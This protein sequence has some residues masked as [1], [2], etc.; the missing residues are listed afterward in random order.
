[1]TDL[2]LISIVTPSFNQG[3]FLRETLQSLVDQNY[4]RLEVIIQDGGSTDD[5][6]A[7][8]GDFVR[9]WPD[10]F[11]LTVETD[12]G[13]A[14]ALNLGFAKTHGDIL[15]FLNSDDTLYPGCL[16]SVARELDPA[17]GRDVVFG[18]SL[19][20]GEGAAY[21]GVEHPAEFK[22]HFE[23]LAIWK[24]GYNTLPQPSVFWT[25]RVWETSGGFD[26]SEGHALDYD[27]F[28]RFSARYAF[29]K[30]DELWSTYRL[31]ADS[32][33]AQKSEAE[34][35]ALSVAVSRKHWGSWLQPLRWRCEVSHWLHDRHLHERAR[36]HARRS[37][38]A[39]ADG[40]TARAVAEFT[41][42]LAC[43]PRMAWQRLLQ[44][45]LAG[46]GLHWLEKLVWNRGGGDSAEYTARHTDGWIG[47]L[48]RQQL[49]V[50]ADARRL[51]LQ[52]QHNPQGGS[53]H[54]AIHLEAWLNGK[55][56]EKMT[57]TAAGP[58]EMSI[59]LEPYRGK[60]CILELRTRPYFVPSAL[61][62][63]SSDHRR[64]TA[65]LIECVVESH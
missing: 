5:A 51:R 26:E 38:Q 59:P 43:S 27:L 46:R 42:T 33:S 61:T 34:V 40:H 24:R 47:P 10:V 53:H 25:R 65:L 29:H 6:V 57:V 21:V 22:S 8:A 9:R 13:Q 45:L 54:Q 48:Y 50:P 39:F 1:M 23:Q 31:H 37:E 30:V 28:C 17:L 56:R 63:G 44:P 14:H 2:P 19:F 4:P 11:K 60:P 58:F 62:E 3:R 18:R 20:T 35:L 41:R 7:V 52:L 36:H 12:R 15:G 16:H 64:L 49:D 55:V 32:K